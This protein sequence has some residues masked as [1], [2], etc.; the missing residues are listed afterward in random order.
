MAYSFEIS[1]S[2]L[3][4][5]WRNLYR[6]FITILWEAISNARDADAQ[7]VWID[8][9]RD[10]SVFSIKDDW[11]WMTW[12]D[13][14]QKFLKVWWSK[15]NESSYSGKWRP[16]IWRK[17]IWKLALLSCSERIS[18]ITKKEW[19]E[20][21]VYWSIDNHDLDQSISENNSNYILETDIPND[22]INKFDLEHGTLLYFDN[23]KSW[24]INTI[25]YLKKLISLYFRFSLI[26][27]DFK[28]Y[29]N[30]E[31]ISLDDLSDLRSSTQFVWDLNGTEDPFIGDIK[32]FQQYKKILNTDF[33]VKGFIASVEKPKNLKIYW[34]DEKITLDLFVNWRLREK[35]LLRHISSTRIT[36]SYLYG[37]IH[38]DSLDSGS[39]SEDVFTTNREWVIASNEQ[40][41]NLLEKLKI[42]LNQI[43]F[44]DW[45]KR[46]IE[47]NQDWDEENDNNPILTKKE[48]KVRSFI[49]E[50]ASEYR[51]MSKNTGQSDSI[52]PLDGWIQELSKEAEFNLPSYFDCFLSENLLRRYIRIKNIPISTISIDKSNQWKEKEE[53]N[54]INGNVPI[55]IRQIDDILSYLDMDHLCDNITPIQNT[56]WINQ[57]YAGLQS[58]WK[59]YKPLRDAVGHTALLTEEAKKKLNTVYDSIKAKIKNL[60]S[61]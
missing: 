15:R 25:P 6:N 61:T 47:A 48:R 17:W 11:I 57:N 44:P 12:E 14:Q 22:I 16:Y 32:D 27:P 4:H 9:N 5:L 35:D 46:R 60:L 26:D 20:E 53:Q 2:V 50:A 34:T 39:S 36:E 42:I 3:N 30:G 7:N 58:E 13:F 23:V 8:I 49:H 38:L 18:I 52:L 59:T 54:K 56:P 37:Q 31:P 55:S 28:I 43:V 45:D 19:S 1:L 33:E 41:K 10:E 21:V 51:D 40:F 24:I 29:V